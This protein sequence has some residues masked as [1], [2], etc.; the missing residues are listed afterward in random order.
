MM[1]R[2]KGKRK[3]ESKKKIENKEE[4]INDI[5]NSI[6]SIN[7]NIKND[8]NDIEIERI[9]VDK[10]ENKEISNINKEVKEVSSELKENDEKEDDNNFKLGE[11]QNKQVKWAVFFMIGIILIVVLFFAIKSNFIDKFDYKGLEFQKTQLGDIRFYSARFPV[12]SGTGQ[13]IGDYAVNL[14]NDPRKLNMPI[15]TT[16]GKI[17]F[18]VDRNKYGDVYISLNPFMKICEDSGIAVLTISS[19]LRDSGL[20]VKSAVTDKAYARA[21][22]LTQRWCDN[23]VYDTI[24]IVTDGNETSITEIYPN[25]Y[26]LKF[27]ECE[28]LQVSEKFILLIL[29]DY[30]KKFIKKDFGF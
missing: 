5:K 6:S 27:K 19:F 29:E 20:N 9:E 18:T 12:V 8:S 25:C 24:I 23:S 26:E 13:V 1:D 14:R 2:K 28:V 22:N 21:N 7:K 10:I 15:N 16:T 11:I 3:V 17:E 4:S 30:A